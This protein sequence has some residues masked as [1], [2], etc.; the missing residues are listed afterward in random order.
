M[1]GIL[2]IGALAVPGVGPLFV[3]GTIAAA[4]T[5][6]ALGAIGGGLIGALGNAGVPEAE[7]RRYQTRVTEGYLLL[8]VQATDAE[9]AAAVREIFERNEATDARQ[10]GETA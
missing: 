3:G 8:S 7:A 6:A 5:G 10:Y 2:A 9:Q 1:G 4:L